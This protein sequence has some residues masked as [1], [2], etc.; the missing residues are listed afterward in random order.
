MCR[1]CAHLQ[2]ELAIRTPGELAKAIRTAQA[3]VAD[4]TLQPDEHLGA[5]PIAAVQP[6][7]PWLD[8]FFHSFRCAACGCQFELTVETYHGS[9]GSWRPR[10]DP[11]IVLKRPFATPVV[12][13]AAYMCSL[14]VLFVLR[15]REMMLGLTPDP[16]GT[17]LWTAALVSATVVVV[18]NAWRPLRLTWLLPRAIGQ[19]LVTLCSPP[20]VVLAI[21]ILAPHG[22]RGLSRVVPPM[23]GFGLG[24]LTGLLVLTLGPWRHFK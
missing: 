10:I 22:M 17:K 13:G 8:L 12:A 1:S 7:G 5:E 11:R 18:L 4:G 23:L 16:I 3:N 21:G 24:S 15:I 19:I 6:D 14:S 20:L 2:A 9:G